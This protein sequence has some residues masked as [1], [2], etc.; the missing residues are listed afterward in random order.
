[1]PSEWNERRTGTNEEI[2]GTAL[3]G[4]DTQYTV[5]QKYDSRLDT[6]VNFYYYWVRGKTTLPPNSKHRKNTVAFVAN[7]ISNPR[8]FD[9][10]YYAITDTNKLAIF[11][12]NDLV[13]D[14]IVLNI[15]IRTNDFDGDS[16]SVWKLAREGDAED[17]QAT[18][19]SW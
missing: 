5:V 3:Y 14:D 4:D 15:D 7:L 16:H 6:F 19:L 12:V 18:T 2:S 9:I 11:N 8:S 17:S 1:M 10:K 13:S